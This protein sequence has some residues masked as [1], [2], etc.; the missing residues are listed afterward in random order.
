MISNR[1]GLSNKMFH[2]IDLVQSIIAFLN[3]LMLGIYKHLNQKLAFIWQLS[4]N[5]LDFPL[6]FQF[7]PQYLAFQLHKMFQQSLSLLYKVVS[8]YM[9]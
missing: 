2:N 9:I 8:L 1:F 5:S 4:S 3:F 7:L 6:F